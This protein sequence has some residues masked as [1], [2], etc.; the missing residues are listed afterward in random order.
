ML[1]KGEC[2]DALKNVIDPEIGLNIVDVGLIYRVEPKQDSIEVDFTLTSPGCPLADTIMA[3]IVRELQQATGI[4]NI[5]PQLVWNPPWSIDFMSEE[6][7]LEL[8]YP[9]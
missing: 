4:E 6:A 7:R 8:G 9:I 5:I 2:L 3:D 1:S